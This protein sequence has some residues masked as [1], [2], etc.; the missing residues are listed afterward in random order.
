MKMKNES[1]TRNLHSNGSSHKSYFTLIELLVVIAII[2]ILA[3]LLI[4]AL[5]QARERSLTSSCAS[6]QRQIGTSIFS[7]SSDS[8]GFLPLANANP[9]TFQS[10]DM[11]HLV[12]LD[13]GH[14]DKD[15]LI[16]PDD[17]VQDVYKS[18]NIQSSPPISYSYNQHFGDLYTISKTPGY[19]R[20][21]RGRRF[22][23][24][25]EPTRSLLVFDSCN[26]LTESGTYGN[27][28]VTGGCISFGAD[29]FHARHNGGVKKTQRYVAVSGSCNF[30]LGDGH[31]DTRKA[32]FASGKWYYLDGFPY[33]CNPLFHTD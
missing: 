15:I 20:I 17:P 5:K 14:L 24:F 25:K 28:D 30:L 2:S 23:E 32:P 29:K 4:P 10:Y 19:S 7:Y 22:S 26:V 1:S 11:W 33:N 16:C 31:V 8:D 9:N 3:S 12:M 18:R 27:H 6:N 13:N 21:L